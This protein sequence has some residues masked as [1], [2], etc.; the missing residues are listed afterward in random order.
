MKGTQFKLMLQFL[1]LMVAAA[2]LAVLMPSA[3]T[4]TLQGDFAGVVHDATGAVVPNADVAIINEATNAM[5]SVKTNDQ[6]RYQARGF[7]VGTYRVEAQAIGFQKAIA[8][9]IEL[10]PAAVT[11]V[12]L[13][14]EVAATGSSVTVVASA[15]VIQSEGGT[16]NYDLDQSAYGKYQM[17]GSNMY[18][19]PFA[20][21]QWTGAYTTGRSFMEFRG[22]KPSFT[23]YTYDGSSGR[24]V[25][26]RIPELSVRSEEL[27]AFGAPA[28]YR[29]AVTANV[30]FKSGTNDLH[31]DYR[32]T[33][34]NPV[35]N[36]VKTPFYQGE[37]SP[38]TSSWRQSYSIGGPV[39]LPKYD[40]RNKTFFYHTL[41]YNRGTPT[42]EN[43]VDSIPTASMLNGD[44]SSQPMMITDP[45]SGIAF[46]NNTIPSSRIS[47]AA[48]V[49]LAEHY[50]KYSYQ[51]AANSTNSNGVYTAIDN[52]PSTTA[53]FKID[54]NFKNGDA[55][56]AYYQFSDVDGRAVDPYYWT[57]GAHYKL[58]SFRHTHLFS[59]TIVNQFHIGGSRNLDI[60]NDTAPG[61]VEESG[62]DVVKRMGL[63]GVTPPSDWQGRPRI[64]VSGWQD[65]WGSW[66]GSKTIYSSFTLDENVN[67]NR[68]R[69]DMKVGFSGKLVHQDAAST[70]E[71]AGS[72]AFNG[73]F[74]GESLADLLLGYPS[75][76]VRAYPRVWVAGRRREYGAFAQDTFRVTRSFQ[77]SYGLRFDYYTAPVDRNGLYYN[78][79]LA[80][81]SIVVPDQHALKSVSGAWTSDI[82]VRLASDAGYPSS[83]L[84]G[85][86]HWAPR[87]SFS[88]R[89]ASDWVVRGA[90]GVYI[91]EMGTNELQTGGPFQVS[92]EYS[93]WFENGAPVLTLQNG[94]PQSQ[95]QVGVSTATTVNPAFRSANVQNWNMTLE[96]SLFTNWGV[97]LSYIG[98]KSTNLPY[99]YDAN[100]P[101]TLSGSEYT[102]ER[103][104]YSG[105]SYI[106][107]WTNGAN[108]NYHGFEA[109]IRHPFRKGFYM[110]ASFSL[111]RDRSEVG[112]T[113]TWS[114]EAQTP[115][116]IDYAYDRARDMGTTMAWT[117][118]AFHL[119]WV[120]EVPVGKGRT[121]ASTAPPVV[122]SILGNWAVSGV[123][124]WRSGTHFTP[125]FS[126][127]D[128]GGIDQWE[129]RPNLV[130]GCDPYA[131][132][133]QL[134]AG[135]MWFNPA[136]Y[137]VPEPGTLGNVAVGSLVGP[138]A[139]MISLNPYKTMPITDRVSLQIGAR[140]S[141]LFNHPV[142]ANP[143]AYI[144]SSNAG[145]IYGSTEML[146]AGSGDG[147]RKIALVGSISF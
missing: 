51:G 8:K 139:W 33:L 125:M 29:R 23:S 124:V 59:P 146:R 81:R 12:D 71:F 101:L 132:G 75:S 55:L 45:L 93:N 35:L 143:E 111:N 112:H 115:F 85:H 77:V 38:G 61:W 57:Q 17:I 36:A 79:D 129:G 84:N 119:N 3:Y 86:G 32:A 66:G 102:P 78:F 136:C 2:L 52:T 60:Q 131:G 68:G 1:K 65:L 147:T 43:R 62:A 5:R 95:T 9:G 137:A 13:V 22:A 88:Y 15:G 126:G 49:A 98:N 30:T 76:S 56:N 72:Y 122:N 21:L 25:D 110:Q 100:T 141:N 37:N 63:D 91:G 27:V 121:F 120:Y 41:E 67:I 4:Q 14:L 140:I 48:Q 26:V 44:Y 34:T 7:Y 28:E 73:R 46:P 99:V 128:T 54:H 47:R 83:I 50:G 96:K 142:Y 113:S 114:G 134:G 24:Q 31:G 130:A 40:G 70:G 6:G 42:Y 117:T 133:K 53:M 135:A 89:P 82:P 16:L 103:R 104:P 107:A 97:R 87:F 109:S 74:A 11:P 94:F 20:A 138:G 69:H 106:S 123:Y 116:W 10:K 144:T 19:Q 108:A 105:F 118:G 92:E 80:S 39:I 64:S 58:Y 127:Y 90:Y 145:Q 18:S